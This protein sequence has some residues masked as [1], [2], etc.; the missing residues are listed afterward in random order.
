MADKVTNPEAPITAPGEKLT[1]STPEEMADTSDALDALLKQTEN[2]EE[3]PETPEPEPTPEPTPDPEPEPK[4]TPDPEPEPKPGEDDLDKVVLPPYTK[5]KSVEAFA[6]VKQMARE[7]IASV[8]RERDEIAAKLA[9]AEEAA[10]NVSPETEAE[11]KELRAFRLK[12]DVAADPSFTTYDQTIQSN[13]ELIYSRLKTAGINDESIKKI[14]EL[15]GPANVDWEGIK[16]KIPANLMR[17]IEGKIFENGDLSEKKKQ[18]IEAAQKNAEEFVKTRQDTFHKQTEGRAKATKENFDQML[19]RF[20]WLKVKPV[21]TTAKAAEK[22]AL[23]A[24]NAF[25]TKVLADVNEALGDDS[26][27]MRAIMIASYAQLMKVRAD[28]DTMKTA[29]AAEIAK[30]NAAIKEKDAFIAS[31]KKS[32]TH[33]LTG[34][35]GGGSEAPKPTPKGSINDDPGSILDAHLKEALSKAE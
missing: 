1:G 32:S 14:R 7:K 33:R 34:K 23:E 15:G 19:P 28:Q 2:P 30:L 11:L 31:V 16:D 35:G 24:Q 18:A 12:F 9:A 22:A 21:P 5:P 29:H 13:E 25:T 17:Y 10:K 3:N 26:P 20:D 6:T 8:T 27:E 4:P